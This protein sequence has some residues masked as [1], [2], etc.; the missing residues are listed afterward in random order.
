MI[1]HT[2]TSICRWAWR[3]RSVHRLP[4]PHRGCASARFLDHAIHL[5]KPTRPSIGLTPWHRDRTGARLSYEVGM[6]HDK[7]ERT[8]PGRR[9]RLPG[10]INNRVLL[11]QCSITAT[12]F[13]ECH[14]SSRSEREFLPGMARI[15]MHAT[16]VRQETLNGSRFFASPP[17]PLLVPFERSRMYMV[18]ISIMGLLQ[19]G[20]YH[21]RPQ[22]AY[23]DV[24]GKGRREGWRCYLLQVR[25]AGAPLRSKTRGMAWS[26]NRNRIQKPAGS[27]R[28]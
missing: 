4:C 15:G 11:Y 16:C 18:P 19:M 25:A 27:N 23:S 21:R 5:D 3:T 1:C 8:R 14:A 17:N 6:F 24:R 20:G 10:C 2:G 13:T 28:F 22:S 7:T 26:R 9:R 12:G